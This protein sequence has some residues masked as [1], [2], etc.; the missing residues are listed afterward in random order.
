MHEVSDKL[1]VNSNTLADYKYTLAFMSYGPEVRP[2]RCCC[3]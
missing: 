1:A 3:V 2:T